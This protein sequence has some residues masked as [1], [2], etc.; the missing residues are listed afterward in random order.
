GDDNYSAADSADHAVTINKAAQATLTVTYPDAG[1]YGDKLVP[2]ASGGS[3]TG[4]LTFTAAGTACSIPTTGGDAGK[5]LITSA[6]GTCSVTAH[7]AG[8][9]NYSAADSADH[10]VTVGQAT[11]TITASSPADAT[12]GDAVPTI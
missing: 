3:G 11:L 5:L 7:N 12:Y 8:D 1:T 4:A 9:D 6:T 10:A 2:T